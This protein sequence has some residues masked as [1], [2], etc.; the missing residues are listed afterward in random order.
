MGKIIGIDLGTTNSVVAVMEGGEPTVITNP[1]GGRVTP[2]VVAV[3]KSGEKRGLVL[4]DQN[5]HESFSPR[6]LG[7]FAIFGLGRSEKDQSDRRALSFLARDFETSVHPSEKLIGSRESNAHAAWF[8]RE[9]CL[10]DVGQVG[11]VDS[12]TLVL[13]RNSY[14]VLV[15]FRGQDP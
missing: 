14:V 10:K 1:E 13:H 7:L 11:F 8:G 2:S 12:S 15:V 3:T 6:L 9:E 5:I 4:H